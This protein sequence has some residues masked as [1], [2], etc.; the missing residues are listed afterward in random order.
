[1][2]Q[3]IITELLTRVSSASPTLFKRLQAIFFALAGIVIVLIFAAPLHLNLHGLEVYVNWNTVIALL[4]GAGLN[5]LPVS[6]PTVLQKKTN[7]DENL[8]GD[9]PPVPPIKP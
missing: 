2:Q 6:D 4:T 9:T 8:N 5:M 1:M 7:E 3:N